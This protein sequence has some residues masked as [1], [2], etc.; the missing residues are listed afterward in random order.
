MK[1]IVGVTGASGFVGSHVCNYLESKGLI[2]EKIDLRCPD[3]VTN[4]N[5]DVFIH[6]AGKAHD[7]RG[8]SEIEDYFRVNVELTKKMFWYFM[9]SSAKSFVYISSVKAVADSTI[10]EALHETVD[11]KPLTPYGNS[12]MMAENF[13]Q[14]QLIPEGKE[15]YVLRP[16]M[17]HGPGNKGNLNLLFKVVKMGIPWPL[18]LFENKRSF[19]SI[20][21][22]CFI[23]HEIVKEKIP[24]GVYNVADTIPFSTN[25]LIAL[26]ARELNKNCYSWNIPKW[27]VVLTARLGDALKLPFNTERLKKLTDNYVISNQK[28]L[29]AL[30]AP[31][32]VTAH[33]G[34][35]K[36]IKSFK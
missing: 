6:L 24:S 18:G 11:P 21:N 9:E 8:T 10:D 20:E 34:L 15:I 19:L 25:D 35:K 13:L 16:C 29:N 1:T 32:P 31:L 28:L 7:L 5:I 12:K 2:V 27:L 4:L 22:F 3:I 17:I 26:I 33:D 30:G 14:E 36:T 23:I